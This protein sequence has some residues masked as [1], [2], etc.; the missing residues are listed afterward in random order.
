MIQETGVIL[1]AINHIN[2]LTHNT[3]VT[4]TFVID[5]KHDS[6]RLRNILTLPIGRKDF[7]NSVE[8]RE[9]VR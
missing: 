2:I 8:L 4:E 5:H 7:S 6:D 1:S 9:G 3:L